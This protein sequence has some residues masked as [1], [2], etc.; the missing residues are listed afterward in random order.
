MSK[1]FGEKLRQCRTLKSLT[2]RDVERETGIS[3]AYLSQLEQA[4]VNEPS[5]HIL[6]KLAVFYEIPYGTLLRLAG[7][8]PP[9]EGTQTRRAEGIA[10]S[11]LK[12]KDITEEEAEELVK[13]LEF[14]RQKKRA[15]K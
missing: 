14:I 9:M 6:Q 1:E 4:K 2:L 11:L 15:V 12:R 5:P 8:L 7:Y 3:N 13:Y 10:F